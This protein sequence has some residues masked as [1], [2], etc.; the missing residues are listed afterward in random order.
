[1]ISLICRMPESSLHASLFP[2]LVFTLSKAG[3]ILNPRSPRFFLRSI[4]IPSPF[5]TQRASLVFA[6]VFCRRFSAE[7]PRE[8]DNERRVFRMAADDR[9]SFYESFPVFVFTR[10]ERRSRSRRKASR[11]CRGD[12]V[13]IRRPLSAA[14]NTRII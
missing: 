3:K 5:A 8:R 13:E 2:L 10:E 1:M 4:F 14:V 11:V 7:G 9:E 12:A 6:R